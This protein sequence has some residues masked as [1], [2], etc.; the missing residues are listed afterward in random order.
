ML[1]LL[2]SLLTYTLALYALALAFAAFLLREL[3]AKVLERSL[4]TRDYPSRKPDE[5]GSW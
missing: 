4:H 1:L 5:W 3:S 2:L